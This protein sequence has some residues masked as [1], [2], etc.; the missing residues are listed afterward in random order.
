MKHNILFEV[1][2]GF[3]PGHSTDLDLTNA[4][5]RL[6]DAVDKKLIS[7]VVFLDLSKI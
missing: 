4:L 2:Y 7:V 3:L 1:Q 5:D 6:C